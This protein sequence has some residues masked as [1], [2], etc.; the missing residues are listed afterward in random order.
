[1]D[2]LVSGSLAYDRIMDFPG[3]FSDHLL[4]GKAHVI[5][6]SFTVDKM[7]ENFGGTAGNIAFALAML[8]ERARIRAT[9]GSDYDRYFRWMGEHDIS[10]ASIR[11]VEEELTASAFITTDLADNQIT[12]FNPGAMKHSAGSDMTGI[13][14]KD[15]IA[16]VSPGNGDDMTGYAGAYRDV[17]L[18]FIFDPGQAIP[19]LSGEQLLEG[20]RGSRLLIANDYE[21]EMILGKAEAEQSELLELTEAIITTRGE[22]GSVIAEADGDSSIPAIPLSKVVDPTGAGDAYRAALIKGLIEGK[23]LV[24]SAKMGA[25]C[26][27]YAVEVYGTQ[28]YRFTAEEFKERYEQHFG[29]L[30]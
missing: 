21:M 26:A 22:H 6:I 14:P 29:P 30:Y 20:I 8:G 18:P 11:V 12:A 15:A 19:V 27:A 17:G 24:T 7:V 5:N 28:T 13:D 9:I 4:P 16:I 23:D 1:V 10:T 2:I 25:V 3:R